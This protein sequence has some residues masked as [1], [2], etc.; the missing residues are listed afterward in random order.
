MAIRFTSPGDDF[1]MGGSVRVQPRN[2]STTA[3]GG[4]AAVSG[5]G[6]FPQKKF[7]ETGAAKVL[8]PDIGPN[9]NITIRGINVVLEHWAAFQALVPG[10]MWVVQNRAG[11]LITQEARY[12]LTGQ[13]GWR[14]A[15]LTGDTYN[16]LHHFITTTPREVKVS[17][18]PTTW[19]APFI[20]YGL[21]THAHIGPRPF[22]AF[23]TAQ[24]LPYLIQAYADLALVAK[25]GARARMTAPR[26]REHTTPYLRKWRQFLYKAEEALG[27]I[28]P[29]GPVGITIPGTNV[30]RASL[31]GMARVLGDIQ[32]VMGR[33]VGQRFQRRLTG[34]VTGRLIGVGSRTIFADKVIGARITGGER[35]YN[36]IAGGAVTRY[37]DQSRTLGGR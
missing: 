16:S 27:D 25:Y 7:L 22:M 12:A 28:A 23:G 9:I 6:P 1:G 26:F 34:K 29:L 18:G 30:F 31:L 10:Y 37:I 32:S 36:R 5:L 21:A 2:I 19:Y 14:P 35:I 17:V 33:V 20:E 4:I 24:V 11:Q 8:R 13:A 15:I 3:S